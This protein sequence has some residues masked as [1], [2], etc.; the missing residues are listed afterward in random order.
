MMRKLL[1]LLSSFALALASEAKP[2][3]PGQDGNWYIGPEG[4]GNY[5][6]I[7]N[8]I[9]TFHM[10]GTEGTG[11]NPGV[12]N[13][14]WNNIRGKLNGVTRIKFANDCLINKADLICFLQGNN[15]YVDLFD[16]TNG[17]NAKMTT[18]A[19]DEIITAAVDDM[20]ANSWQAKGIIL[21]LNT[22][23]GTS[24]VEKSNNVWDPKP[25]FTEYAAYYRDT[26]KTATIY[27]HDADMRNNWRN[28]SNNTDA[29]NHYNTAYAHL[30]SHSEVAQA[31]TYLVSTNNKIKNQDTGLNLSN[32]PTNVTKISIINDEMVYLNDNARS[33]LAVITVEAAKGGNFAAAVAN[34]NIELTP[35]EKL[36]VK[37]S[38]NSADIAA[39]NEFSDANLAGPKV[40]NLADA[41]GVAKADLTSITNSKV[42]FIILPHAMAEEQIQKDLF[43][44]VLTNSETF[45]AAIATSTD[46]TTLSAYV[47]K[48]GSLAGARCYATGNSAN[49]AGEY[50]PTVQGLTTLTLSGN[51][52]QCDINANNTSS[53]TCALNGELS[54]ITSLDLSGAYFANVHDMMLGE[55]GEVMI[56][57]NIVMLPGAGFNQQSSVLTEIK[58]PNDSRMTEIP[59]RC[60]YGVSTVNDLHIP[61]NFK[62]IGWVAFWQ[63]NIDHITTEDAKGAL[64]DNGPKT[65]TFSAAITELGEAG[66]IEGNA[67]FPNGQAITD[68][69]CL[70]MTAPVCYAHTFHANI[71][72]GNGGMNDGIYCRDKY[73]NG[74]D[75]IAVLHFPSQ[76][77]YDNA[78]G[79]KESSYA[80]LVSK[81]TDPTRNYSKKDQT[82]AVDA[83]GKT[84]VWPDQGE[85]LGARNMALA[86]YLWEDY[87]NMEYQ[88]EG[89]AHLISLHDPT[90]EQEA[91]Y[92]N[93]VGWHEFVLSLATYVDPD[94]KIEEEKIVREYVEAGWY[95]FCIPFDMTVSQVQ[96]MLGVPA[97][98]GN[99]ICKLNG[100]EVTEPIMPD[101]RQLNS[102]TRKKGAN[103]NNNVVTLRLTNDLWKDSKG[104]YLDFDVNSEDPGNGQGLVDAPSNNRGSVDDPRCLVGGRP[105]FIKAYRRAGDEYKIKG[106][107]LGMAIMTRYAD[108]FGVEASCVA[109]GLY[110]Q[111][112]NSK[113][114][115]LVTLRFAIPYENHKVQALKDCED[116]DYLEYEEDGTKKRYNYTMVGQFWQ[117]SL[118]QYCFYS[119][120]NKWYRYT[121]TSKKYTWDPYK[122]IIMAT[123]E[124]D[125][126]HPNGGR[127]RDN[128]KS[129]YPQVEEG[130]I[131]LLKSNFYLGFLDGRDD[132]DFQNMQAAEYI[133]AFDDGITEYDEAGYEVTAIESLDGESTIGVPAN[134]KVYNMSGQMV[135]TSIDNLGKGLYIVNGKK[136]VVK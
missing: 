88:K 33:Y 32:L 6:T 23:S 39:I 50:K 65:Y 68:V 94:E 117:Q 104:H 62:K 34:T 26:Q 70:G 116:V 130:T 47:N 99:V 27:A 37:G 51:L 69:Y 95:T 41:T 22:I 45:K 54:T 60:L 29:Q 97:S 91:F 55:G 12:I 114:E 28:I 105:Y 63:T 48:A 124:I 118:P 120:K 125:D 78:A 131:D 113:G 13:E 71:V 90:G 134:G 132:D 76:E 121:D 64:I 8:G 59:A 49:N 61:Y 20:V 127:Y 11:A 128:A 103:G 89:T 126:N 24:R 14:S 5:F 66:H 67:V 96:Q 107:N 87:P 19:I 110:E 2:V 16:I 52:N 53:P 133:F 82:G 10:T 43:S 80:D 40:Y 3:N 79:N 135:G 35:C 108:K 9:A 46:K 56:G 21:P 86:G 84:L 92:P 101:I 136:F 31:G 57:E 112:K 74:D 102:V 42:E 7:E 115:E 1:F 129:N 106:Q 75:V 119:S 36:I 83:N 25:T 15:Y 93:Y 98:A 4:E 81:F 30:S 109:N 85:L 18:A 17:E 100:V 72:Y 73:H 111:L 77:S 58:L 122:C 123:P 38:V 44:Q